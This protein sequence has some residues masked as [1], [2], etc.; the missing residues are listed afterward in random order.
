MGGC[1]KSTIAFIDKD[2]NQDNITQVA[3][4]LLKFYDN[5]N[6][7]DHNAQSNYDDAIR[8]ILKMI[9]DKDEKKN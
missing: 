2:I 6:N 7:L 3:G 4:T 8:I 9:A 5:Y 1:V